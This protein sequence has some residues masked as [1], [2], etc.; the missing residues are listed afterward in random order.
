LVGTAPT[1]DWTGNANAIATFT[2]AGWRFA[3]AVEGMQV[4]VIS[5]TLP[6]VYNGAQWQIGVLYGS[7]LLING[8]QVVSSQAA[9][10]SDPA[11][12]T[13]TDAEARSAISSILAALRQHGLISS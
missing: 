5:A 12:G 4:W 11:G 7:R 3:A 2:T 13:T 6:A 10:I 9:P 1:G 8:T